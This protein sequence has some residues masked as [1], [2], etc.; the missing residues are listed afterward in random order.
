VGGLAD[1]AV[2]AGGYAALAL[3]VGGVVF[4]LF[5][6][7]PMP[8]RESVHRVLSRMQR[9]MLTGAAL[10]LIAS[11]A[12]SAPLVET[13]SW[14]VALGLVANAGPRLAR[15]SLLLALAAPV[16]VLILS[17]ALSGHADHGGRLTESAA[18]VHVAAMSIWTG[19]LAALL[20]M[21][22]GLAGREARLIAPAAGRFSVVA[23]GCVA[24]VLVTG[25]AQSVQALGAAEDLVASAFGRAVLLKVALFALALAVAAAHHR[26]ISLRVA[27]A[28]ETVLVALVVVVAGVVTGLQPPA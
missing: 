17:A 25:V 23:M 6:L 13:A 1:D 11:I 9:V 5:V 2:R 21:S 24:A 18:V 28:A 12:R 4:V 22:L 26:R 7:G 16:W 14:A 20:L 19:G 15:G 10:G 27:L 8:E 3:L